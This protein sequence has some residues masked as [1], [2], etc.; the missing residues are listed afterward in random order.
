MM[1]E[2]FPDNVPDPVIRAI[3]ALFFLICW[4]IFL[5][6]RDTVSDDTK[7]TDTA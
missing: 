4:K 3:A 1:A 7:P 6:R 2:Q 5:I